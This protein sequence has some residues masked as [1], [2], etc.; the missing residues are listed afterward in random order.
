MGVQ[1]SQP[2]PYITM[3]IITM[4]TLELHTVGKGREIKVYHEVNWRHLEHISKFFVNFRTSVFLIY[5]KI[6]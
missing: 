4:S 3:I 5:M 1:A 2:Q 6:T